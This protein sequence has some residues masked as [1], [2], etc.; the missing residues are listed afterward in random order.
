M[1]GCCLALAS[2]LL[3]KGTSPL[4]GVVGLSG[5][6]VL[7]IDIEKEVNMNDKKK[8]KLLLYNGTK[9]I[10]FPI[11]YARKRYEKLMDFDF[12]ISLFE[13]EELRQG[14]RTTQL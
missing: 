1:Q 7:D 2:F 10:G 3:H 12:D 4:G 5:T 13:D 11:E 9:D 14:F 8:T 6:H